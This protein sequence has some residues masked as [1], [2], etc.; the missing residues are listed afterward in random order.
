MQSLQRLG[1]KCVEASEEIVA[2][3]IYTLQC[4]ELVTCPHVIRWLRNNARVATERVAQH[5]PR[6]QITVCTCPG[7]N[8][9]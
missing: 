8:D 3:Y 7:C 1:I 5:V 2:S 4:S 9:A 6:D